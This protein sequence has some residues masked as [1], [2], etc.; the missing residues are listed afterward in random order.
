MI[1]NRIKIKKERPLYIIAIILLFAALSLSVFLAV[2]FGSSA[3]RC[4]MS[5]V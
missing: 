2:M 3:Y 4:A 5:M 1:R